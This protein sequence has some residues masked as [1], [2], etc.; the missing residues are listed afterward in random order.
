MVIFREI[1]VITK[2]VNIVMLINKTICLLMV[3]IAFLG[4]VYA[5]DYD[6]DLK[7]EEKDKGMDY[8]TT[9]VWLGMDPG[10]RP[11][12]MGKAFTSISDDANA[13]YWNPAGLGFLQMREVNFMH[14]PR[15]FEGGND[16][17]GGMF[18][19]FA[20]FVFPAGKLG[21]L[22]IGF[23][24]HDHGK[25]EARDDQGNL[26]GIIHSYAFSPSISIGRMITKTISVGTTFRYAYEHLTDDAK[27]NTY[28][29]DFGFLMRP[30]F[31]KGRFGYAFVLKN[32]GKEPKEDQ[33]IPR[34]LRLGV[35]CVLLSDRLN[36]LV[37]AFDYS[38]ELIKI[39]KSFKEEVFEQGVFRFGFEYFY[40]DI[41]GFRAGY[42]HDMQGDISGPTF[43]FGVRYKG[44]VFD[45]GNIPEGDDS[46]GRENRFSFSYMF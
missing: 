24:Y 37:V 32:I 26:I 2:E 10:G 4:L 45:F 36:D 29:F 17:L 9:M 33:P 30:E 18:Y 20:S 19:D 15:S 31:A 16:D 42:Y 35:D 21:N 7:D 40:V 12:G 6:S 41:V 38:K 14:E 3:V 34:S 1:R 25:S 44:L 23:L 46:F 27:M 43:G 22:G 8:T 11:A 39:D 5:G 13:T 28:A